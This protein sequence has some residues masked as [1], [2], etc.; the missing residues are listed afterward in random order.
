MTFVAVAI[1]GGALIGGAASMIS[2]NNAA[3]AQQNAANSAN[4]LQ[5]QEFN[6]IEQNQQPWQQAGAQALSQMG[7]PQFQQ[8]FNQSDFQQDPSYQFDLNQGNQALQRSAAASGGLMSGGTLKA[9][10]QYTQGMASNEYQQAYQNFNTN[11]TNQFN[12][13][14]SVAGLGQTANGQVAQSGMNMAGQ[15]GNNTMGA[16]NAQGAA[17]IA[18]GNT[19][20]SLASGGANTWAGYQSAQNQNQL[21]QS[22]YNNGAGNLGADQGEMSGGSWWE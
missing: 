3:N 7:S 16:A 4:Q 13:L 2:S 21:L 20:S 19:L 8:T 9:M 17:D 12:R 10:G 11:Q 6:Q 14:A 22:I 5:A 18:K 15:V 1:G